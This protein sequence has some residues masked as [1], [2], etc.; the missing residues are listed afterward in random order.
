MKGDGRLSSPVLDGVVP[1]SL[2]R[3]NVVLF[4]E[5]ETERLFSKD[6][7]DV[8]VT[9]TTLQIPVNSLG[10]NFD[11]QVK[12]QGR[13]RVEGGDFCVLLFS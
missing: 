6:S 10:E 8:A 5:M 11:G 4:L 9:S 1:C 7:V 2:F 3:I 13:G 12:R